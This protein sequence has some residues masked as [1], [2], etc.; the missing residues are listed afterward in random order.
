MSTFFNFTKNINAEEKPADAAKKYDEGMQQPKG[1]ESLFQKSKE[2]QAYDRAISNAVGSE[3]M[4]ES[5]AVLQQQMYGENPDQQITDPDTFLAPDITAGDA[6]A[7]IGG[8]LIGSIGGPMG[9]LAGAA[10][11]LSV[12][13][14]TKQSDFGRSV[15]A[16]WGDLVE[17]TG[18]TIDFIGSTITPWDP[19]AGI[20]TTVAS[21]L[22]RKGQEIQMKNDVFIPPELENISWSS[23]A[24]PSFWTTK[25]ARLLPYSMSF[26]VP[27]MGAAGA[28]TKFLLNSSKAVKFAKGGS[29]LFK[30]QVKGVTKKNLKKAQMYNPSAKVGDKFL[31]ETAALAKGPQAIVS[32]VGGGIG[33]NLAEGAFVAGETLTEA[34]AA[35]LTPEEASAA[36]KEV[37]TDNLKWIG[38]D[39][40]QFGLTFGG[41]G[42]LSAGMKSIPKSSV[43]FGQ[44]IAPF[45]QAGA[46]GSI[47]GFTEQYQEVYQEWIKRKA[48]YEERPDLSNYDVGEGYPGFM[49]FFNSPEMK[50]TRVSSFALGLTMGARGGYVDAIAERE[51]QLEK[52]RTTFNN[53]LESGA[54]FEQAEQ[55]R[56]E[57]IAG[58]LINDNGNPD[59]AKEKLDRMVAEKQMSVEYAEEIKDSFDEYAEM[60]QSAH[61][62]N[63]LSY[64]GKNQIFL[65]KVKIAQIERFKQKEREKA[66]AAIESKKKTIKNKQKLQEAIEDIEANYAGLE[67]T[68]NQE[69][70]GLDNLVE[71]IATVRKGKMTKDGSRVKRSSKGLT[72]GQFEQYT[73][74]GID[75]A[76][77]KTPAGLLKRAGQAISK[78]PGAIVE[79][80]KAVRDK[81][82][83]V[84]V[85]GAAK[86]AVGAVKEK[87]QE[88]IQS[89]PAKKIVKF[90]QEQK[91]KGSNYVNKYLKENAPKTAEAIEKE[92]EAAL[93]AVGNKGF[94]KEEARKKAEEIIQK[95]KKKDLK[96]ASGKFLDKMTDLTAGRLEGTITEKVISVLNAGLDLVK[97]TA[98]TVKEKV[99]EQRNKPVPDSKEDVFGDANRETTEFQDTMNRMSKRQKKNRVKVMSLYEKMANKTEPLTEEEIQFYQDNVGEFEKVMAEIEK[100]NSQRAPKPKKKS[101]KSLKEI[102]TDV[103]DEAIIVE[104]SETDLSNSLDQDLNNNDLTKYKKAN[105]RGSNDIY[106]I[107]VNPREEIVQRYLRRTLEKQF[108]GIDVAFTYKQLLEGFGAPAAAV[109][110]GSTILVNKDAAMQTDLIHELSHPYYQSIAGTALQKRLNKLLIK[111]GWLTQVAVNYPELTRYRVGGKFVTGQ[112]IINSYLKSDRKDVVNVLSS[113]VDTIRKSQ[114]EGNAQQYRESSKEL[115]TFLSA[116]GLIKRMS[117]EAQYGLLEEAFA[118]SNE[119]YNR[120]GGIFNVIENGKDALET[121]NVFKRIYKR[122]SKFGKNR[123][124]AEGA[125]KTAFP[126]IADMNLDEM[127]DYISKNFNTLN[128]DNQLKKNSYSEKP[129][130]KLFGMESVTTKGMFQI[131]TQKVA[132]KGLKGDAA[133]QEALVE[134]YKMNGMKYSVTKQKAPFGVGSIQHDFIKRRVQSLVDKVDYARYREVLD[135]LADAIDQKLNNQE[136]DKEAFDQERVLQF[137][138]NEETIQEESDAG[139]LYDREE[140]AL[141]GTTSTVIEGFSQTES[142]K[143][144][145]NPVNKSELLAELFAIGQRV[146]KQNAFAFVDQVLNSDNVEVQRFIAFLQKEFG[147]ESL[148]DALLLDMSIDFAN[149]KIET[150]KQISFRKGDNGVNTWISEESLS[151]DEKR[152]VSRMDQHAN[153]LWFGSFEGKTFKRPTKLSQERF[154]VIDLVKAGNVKE[155]F[156]AIYTDSSYYQ[157]ISPEL[158]TETGRRFNYKGKRYGSV[159]EIVQS[160]IKDF[161]DNQGRGDVLQ[162]QNGFKNILTELIVQSRAK[163][164]ITMVNDV[165]ENPTMI[166][167]KENSLHNKNENYAKLRRDN[168]QAYIRLMKSLGYIKDGKFVNPYARIL[169]SGSELSINMLSGVVVA[170]NESF[171]LDRRNRK[172]VKM[173]SQELMLAD[174]NEYLYNLDLNKTNKETIFYDQP[175]AVFGAAKRR[176]YVKSILARTA[177]QK[178]DLVRMAYESGLVNET[179]GDGKRVFPFDIEKKGDKYKLII[180]DEYVQNFKTEILKDK[181]QV[182]LNTLIGKNGSKLT[183]AKLKEFLGNYVINKA[184]AQQLLIGKH[185]ESQSEIDYIKRAEGAIKRHT[186]HDRNTPIEFVA[187]QDLFENEN[188]EYQ[189]TTGLHKATDAEAY[190]LPGDG[191]KIRDKFG[192][193]RKVGH[194]FK[195]VYDYVEVNNQNKNLLGKRTFG[196][197]KIVE[198]TPEMEKNNP[199]LKKIADVLRKRKEV[200][201]EQKFGD[202]Q[203]DH[204]F[205]PVATFGSALKQ[206]APKPYYKGAD[207]KIKRDLIDIDK[208]S[209]EEISQEQDKIYDQTEEGN[210]TGI[211]GEGFGVQVELDK[212]R[213]TFHMPSQLFGHHH[214]NL[215]TEETAIVREMHDLAA[216]AMKGYQNTKKGPVIYKDTSTP[217]ERQ[218]DVDY[219]RKLIGEEFFGNLNTSLAQYAPA[220]LPQMHNLM[221][222]LAA[223]RLV[224]FGTKAMFKGTIAYQVS[225][226][227][228]NLNA[229]QKMSEL[230]EKAP[231]GT[232]KNRLNRYIEEGRDLVVSEG[233]IP[234][235]AKTDGVKIGDV[236]LA[237]RVPAHGKQSTVAIVVK[238]FHAE[239][240]EGA[241]SIISVPSKV[242][243]VIGSDM[244]G[245]SLFLNYEH[246]GNID[247]AI[248]IPGTKRKA[249]PVTNVLKEWQ[250]DANRLLELNINLI[251]DIEIGSQKYNELTTPIDI[252][253]VAKEAVDAVKNFYGKE[254]QRQSQLLPIGD[255]QYFNDNVPAQN[256]IGTVASLQRVLNVMAGYGVGFNFTMNVKGTEKSYNDINGLIDIASEDNAAGNA[257]AVAELL[258]IVLDNAKYQYANKMG[259]TP[260]TVNQFTLLARHGLDL[261]DISI[262]MNNPAVKTYDK[263]RGD[264]SVM[265]VTK[266]SAAI[267]AIMEIGG[268]NKAK[269]KAI[270]KK[271]TTAEINLDISKLKRNSKDTQ[272]ALIGFMDKLESVTDEIFS[273]GKALSV[274]KSMPKHGHDAQSLID[275]INGEGRMSSLLEPNTM[276]NF[277]SDPLI[278]HSID[279][280]QQQVDRQKSTS[281]MYTKEARDII[282]YIEDEKKI[283]LNFERREHRKIIEDYYLMKVAEAIPALNNN[284]TIG[285]VYN[286]IEEY[287]NRKDLPVDN[288]VRKYLLLSN[289]S[290]SDYYQHQIEINKK[291]INSFSNEEQIQLARNEFTVLPT[292]IKDALL[293][294]DFIK[295]KLGFERN[296]ITPLFSKEYMR[297][298]FDMLDEHFE[299]EK[300]KE[301]STESKSVKDKATQLFVNHPNIFKD[302]ADKISVNQQKTLQQA[303]QIE[304]DGTAK[305]KKAKEFYLDH[306][307]EINR[308]LNKDEYFKFL[309]YNYDAIKQSDYKSYFDGRYDQYQDEYRKLDAREKQLEE[310]GIDSL[311]MNELNKTI[312]EIQATTDEV[313][314]ARL[315]HKLHLALGKKAMSKQIKNLRNK[316]KGKYKYEGNEDISVIRKWF[317]A[318]NMTSKRPEVQEM[319]NEIQRQYRLYAVEVKKQI[320]EVNKIEKALIKSKRLGLKGLFN[321]RARFELLYGKMIDVQPDSSIR[322]FNR[323]EFMSKNPTQTE[324]EFYN[325]YQQITNSY[326]K[327][328]KRK[329]QDL[330]IPH[331]Q[332]GNLEALSARGLLGL[333][334]NHLGSTSNINHVKLTGVGKYARKEPQSFEFWKNQYMDGTIDENQVTKVRHLRQLQKRA[335]KQLALGK[336]EDGTD[337]IATDLEMDTLMEGGLFSRFN[338][339]RTTRAKELTSYNLADNLKQYVRSVT[340]VHGS[341]DQSFRGFNDVATLVDGVIAVNR[342]MGNENT[343]E[344]VQ[345]VWRD[346]FLRNQRQTSIFG[347]TADKA[348]QFMVRWTALIHLGFSTSVG[349]G[350]ILAGKYQE[351]RDK[352]GSKFALGEKRFWTS[353]NKDGWKGIELLKK[354]RVIELSFSD[355]VGDR[356]SFSKIEQWAFLPMELSEYWI[357]GTAFL[358]ELTPQEYESGIVSDERV[359]EINNKIATLHGEGYT[360]ID[361]R[362]L[363]VYSL[364]VAAQQFKRWFITLA[365]NRLKQEDINRFGEYEIGSYR[366]GYDFVMRMMNGTSKLSEMRAEFEALPQHRKDAIN[367]LLRGF[368]MTAM[369][370]LM[371]MAADDDDFYADRIQKLS[372]DALIFT[373]V[374]RFVN[375]TLPPASINTGKNVLQ[376]SKELATLQRYER[377]GE[378]GK[379]GDLKAFSTARKITP[380]KAITE[381]LFRE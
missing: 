133:V 91:E 20:N 19:E 136:I 89:E 9:T 251:A 130:K 58:M 57:V 225:S 361:Q 1:F 12:A 16:G 135:R 341:V 250:T 372:N 205:T 168:K 65:Q 344:Y 252:E 319:I 196:K 171:N 110:L 175:I 95:I 307:S 188:G 295:N 279:L 96:G 60:F 81:V 122:V 207:G 83:A 128:V 151:M 379:Q 317:G 102:N 169:Y 358:G 238:D 164:Y 368:G 37:Y 44:K 276:G 30:A 161:V 105:T 277:R 35:G 330:Y 313:A 5:G 193:M 354:Y 187:F 144:P 104:D 293:Q 378:F 269:A 233:I 264:Q 236:I 153:P 85:V 230:A 76:Q 303:V 374:N 170:K 107:T 3:M 6:A 13:G 162:I 182:E 345:R 75:E 339:S 146:K 77:A 123:E 38:V 67:E 240:V 87:G 97:K 309:G 329:G 172:Y 247:E 137:E 21:Y 190:V 118:F 296:S 300:D 53:Q 23:M 36:A 375:Y 237:T 119:E 322:L 167:N 271:Y 210:W 245:D 291:Q 265:T 64:E 131:V 43:T 325:K 370:L 183:N 66:D 298:K 112:Q 336:H 158:F 191:Q 286:T 199:T 165:A 305:F 326:K 333:Y 221:Q 220:L 229:Y 228:M 257:F 260:N 232:Y 367:A 121:E 63:T 211:S 143:T 26:F 56:A 356:D 200:I 82:K 334:A 61:Q 267:Q 142:K 48:I 120:K 22:K 109:F 348:I 14:G 231:T 266:G 11:G 108:P 259:L 54:T 192:S 92:V 134:V 197:F 263:Y 155:A 17:G 59:R 55:Q 15:A 315:L 297:G 114:E 62:D 258:N 282:A 343:A 116:R 163:N 241:R 39:M 308:P 223:S 115:F 208:M 262:I 201:A 346:N 253:K 270:L 285:E 2:E 25:V 126:E 18:Q 335:E 33:G 362:L 290:K 7:V 47:E 350:N 8:G 157:Y 181:K 360:K 4:G 178:N 124:E 88:V 179:Y 355:V 206:Y 10:A 338:A 323:T 147:R 195:H 94:T 203:Q 235:T 327:L 186:P 255:K 71:Q 215:T 359:M 288:F 42:R 145:N 27:G 246:K 159:Q 73:T 139:Q 209:V 214:S 99:K 256:M 117:D 219:L 278:K 224:K 40:L 213:H 289:D 113:L 184:M 152:W 217:A 287:N 331:F 50:E 342:E 189:G 340:F 160:N 272:Y 125:V 79:G 69:I 216:K 337:I 268:V 78:V 239:G 141:S 100:Q 46:S 254:E 93:K 242:S 273:I 371:G 306:L 176:Y 302:V 294:Y 243:E 29:N 301:S 51:Y 148:V 34:L 41:L 369:L 52:Q 185:S 363:S 32:A 180:T 218:A 274:H 376:F 357:Q 174:L 98:A 280:L 49:E 129:S 156:D 70:A 80:A 45:L 321:P 366:A 173:D 332:M 72:P 380:A 127:M 349:I 24:D 284:K 90:F 86:E 166:I 154:A 261:K 292:E 150:M 311:S 320:A 101:K 312:Q 244:D 310:K 132:A 248:T 364:G 316:S 28:S 352:G 249:V 177:K 281:F 138:Q 324:I 328:L 194:I 227:G 202:S 74:E 198:L 234:A 222:Q 68:S 318:N 275:T 377:S 351:L 31:D 103:I 373:D 283:K 149:K 111:Q 353:L 106:Q 347:K 212:E 365:Y 204:D 314:N 140:K 84:G 299:S 226:I 304:P 381:P